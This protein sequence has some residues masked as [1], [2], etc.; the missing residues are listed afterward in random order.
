M[1]KYIW[2]QKKRSETANKKNNCRPYPLQVPLTISFFIQSPIKNSNPIISSDDDVLVGCMHSHWTPSLLTV[3]VQDTFKIFNSFFFFHLC[4]HRNV[5][6]QRA[7]SHQSLTIRQCNW[8][9]I[10]LA[11]KTWT[12]HCKNNR[13]QV[14]SCVSPLT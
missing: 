9:G 11:V 1:T 7:Y 5:R 2:I 14:T 4:C 8:I 13:G 12:F 3:T 6:N 10:V